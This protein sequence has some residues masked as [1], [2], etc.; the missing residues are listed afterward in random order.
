[1]EKRKVYLAGWTVYTLVM[2]GFYLYMAFYSGLNSGFDREDQMGIYFT[3]LFAGGVVYAG[4]MFNDYSRKES[5]LFNLLLPASH[6]EKALVHIFFGAVFFWIVITCSFMLID[7][8]YTAIRGHKDDITPFYPLQSRPDDDINVIILQLVYLFGQTLFMLGMV[9]F[10]KLAFFKTSLIMFILI[11]ITV[12]ITTG[13]DLGNNYFPTYSIIKMVDTDSDYNSNN[14]YVIK[15]ETI[16]EFSTTVTWLI[17]VTGALIYAGFCS[18]IW[19]RIKEK[20]V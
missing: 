18:V 14:Y 9:Y 3:A 17:Y 15:K 10:R 12:Q 5:G 16:A 1:M 4:L 11:L 8:P 13:F 2:L 7:I 6:L 20:Q 19:L